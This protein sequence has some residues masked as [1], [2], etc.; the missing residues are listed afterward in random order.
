[1]NRIILSGLIVAV[2]STRAGASAFSDFNQGIS[3]HDAGEPAG[4]VR[5]MSAA[6]AN[7]ALPAHL[8]PAALLDRGQAY[9]VQKQYDL[10]LADYSALL[11]LTPGD[12]TALMERGTLHAMRKE[13]ELARADFAEAIRV[14]PDM[15]R[16][17]AE[18]GAAF[19]AEH[20]FDE[21]LKDYSDGLAASWWSIEFYRLRSEAYRLS[22]RYDAAIK[23][24]EA[25]LARD[26]KY[27]GAYIARGRVHED[28]GELKA[29][30]SDYE[31]AAD[32]ESDNP[33]LPFLEGMV[34]WKLARF[35]D[36]GRSFSHLPAHSPYAFIWNYLAEARRRSAAGDL[37]EKAAKL[38]AAEWPAPVV[39][40]IAGT[41]TPDEVVAKAG[42]E[43]DALQ[44]KAQ[45]C[46]ADFYVGEWQLLHGDEARAK[47]LLGEAARDCEI[48]GIERGAAVVELARLK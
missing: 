6:L 3:A 48:G 42:E 1:M 46:E 4:T 14:R 26:D 29:A 25:A 17:Y 45:I 8:R 44:R 22:A 30:L 12:Y 13:F 2:L 10:A 19:M 34:E 33:E 16:P 40:L 20:R 23:E 31:K 35:D 38:D 15:P 11:A 27:A 41:A 5:Y 24:D 7:T 21:A 39:K 18:H 37:A 32:L 47:A 28:M 36:A 43:K 9:M